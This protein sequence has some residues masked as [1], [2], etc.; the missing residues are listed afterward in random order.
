MGCEA[1][2]NSQQDTFSSEPVT[3]IYCVQNFRTLKVMLEHFFCHQYYD[4]GVNQH[5]YY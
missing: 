2:N 1:I 4:N 3:F 5:G